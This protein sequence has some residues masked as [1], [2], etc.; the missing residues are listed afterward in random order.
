MPKV[1]V[2]GIGIAYEIFGKGDR[3]VAITAGGRFSKDTPGLADLGEKLASA[4]FR[5]L[6]WDRPNCGESDACFDA[7]TESAMNTAAY[8]GL[9]EKVGFGPT[10]FV[11]GSAGARISLL[12]AIRNPEQCAG[13]LLLWVAG[14][15]LGL[16]VLSIHYCFDSAFAANTKGMGAV[17]ELPVWKE[18]L[19][20][21]P[22]NR[23]RFLAQDPKVFYQTMQRWAAAFLPKD[24]SPVPGV[25]PDDLKTIKVPT[26]VLNSGH[27][28][29]HHPRY[30]TEAIAGYIPGAELREPPWPDTEWNDLLQDK[31]ATMYQ[32]WGKLAP[33]VIELAGRIWK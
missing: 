25:S 19:T 24:D 18:I 4:G 12:T 29:V 22:G 15:P 32:N 5:A 6:I 9:L 13:L 21:N 26:I 28:D 14:G 3:T 30:V 1:D 2:N 7:E 23:A 27:S 11:G 20:R 17:V 10:I 16:A 8:A 33:V 31:N